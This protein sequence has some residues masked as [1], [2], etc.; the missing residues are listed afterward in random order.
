MSQRPSPQQQGPDYSGWSFYDPQYAASPSSSATAHGAPPASSTGSPSPL[1]TSSA[2]GQAANSV[3]QRLGQFVWYRWAGLLL[4]A[5]VLG[6]LGSTMLF[7]GGGGGGNGTVGPTAT[8]PGLRNTPPPQTT[9]TALPSRTQTP[10]PTSKQPT[11]TATPGQPGN[12]PAAWTSSGRGDAEF[13]EAATVAEDFTYHYET[14]DW[15]S[16][17]SFDGSTF[18]MTQGALTRFNSRDDRANPSFIAWF[19]KEHKVLTARVHYSRTRLLQAQQAGKQFF[20]WFLVDYSLRHEQPGRATFTDEHTIVVLL[21][22]QQ[23]GSNSVVGGVGWLVADW[24]DNS[25]AIIPLPSTELGG[26]S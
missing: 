19:Q 3:R 7:A 11:V 13:D 20:A 2:K 1:Q 4:A 15:R 22:A 26:S 6:A 5:L 10:T 17:N 21:E 9:S 24:Q 8:P 23:F 16:K 12:L 18:A 14:L 25:D